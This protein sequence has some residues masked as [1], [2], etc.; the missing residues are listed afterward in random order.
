MFIYLF[1]RE[2]Q[3]TSGARGEREGDT[4]SEAGSGALDS[5]EPDSGLEPLN[6]E[7]MT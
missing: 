7:I 6:G 2:K 3:S 4:E 5:S 1:L